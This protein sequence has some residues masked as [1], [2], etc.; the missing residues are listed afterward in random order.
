[1]KTA[2][3]C[4]CKNEENYIKE[5]IDHYFNIGFDKIFVC[6]NNDIGNDSM[7]DIIKELNNENVIYSNWQ[8]KQFC[9][10]EC[11]TKLY[12]DYKNSFDWILFCDID[13]FLEFKDK[14]QDIKTFLSNPIFENA[15]EVRFCWQIYDDN[16]LLD[17]FDGNYSVK[18]FTH[19]LSPDH[20]R[21]D[22]CK[23][24]IQ[25]KFWN[26]KIHAHGVYDSNILA[27]DSTGAKCNNKGCSIS[28]ECKQI[29]G[30]AWLN[31]Y[32]TKT[33]GEYIRFKMFRG[34]VLSEKMLKK[35][36]NINNF[37]TDNKKT[38]E[39]EAYAKKLIKEYKG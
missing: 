32:R 5:W 9:Q 14:S 17:V 34:D 28:T 3:V 21:Q 19:H 25:T 29:L 22:Q 38:P 37:W 39:K 7:Y 33:I 36:V 6:D 26:G 31:H 15:G 13:E 10:V 35:N 23:S 16:G 11:Y 8:G 12:A 18:R 2:V 30:D 24:I 4:I 27:V 1:M 20:K